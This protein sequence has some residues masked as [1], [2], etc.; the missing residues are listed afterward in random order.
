MI[1]TGSQ[2]NVRSNKNQRPVDQTCDPNGEVSVHIHVTYLYNVHPTFST[3]VQFCINVIQ[4]FRVTGS[5]EG[6]KL[7]KIQFKTMGDGLS[8]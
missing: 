6:I 3:L 2:F 1:V 8:D 7:V 5:K 4:M